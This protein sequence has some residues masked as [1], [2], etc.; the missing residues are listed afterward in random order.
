MKPQIYAKSAIKINNIK[1]KHTIGCDGI[2]IQLLNELIDNEPINLSDFKN[3]NIKAVHSPIIKNEADILIEYISNEKYYKIIKETCYIANYFGEKQE[4]LI[5]VILH[6]EISFNHLMNTK[7]LYESIREKI[8]ELLSLFPYIKIGIENVTPLRKTTN[9]ELNL[10]NNLKTDN[11]KLVKKLR[12][13]IGTE[14]LGT[15]LDTCHAMLTEKYTT[16]IYEELKVKTNE[17]LLEQFFK[18]YKD[19]CILIHLC[20]F[21]GDGYTQGNHGTPFSKNTKEKCFEILDLYKKYNYKCPITLKVVET[22][23]LKCDGYKETKK[24]VDSYK[25]N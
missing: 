22:D 18:E 17:Y 4:E 11:I 20:D 1:C 16:V 21:A 8:R 7:I 25:W 10:C 6:S 3:F 12:E 13:D 5:T 19:T 24:I 14:R 2:E 15:V 23:Y 9:K